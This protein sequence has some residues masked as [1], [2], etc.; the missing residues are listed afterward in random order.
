MHEY[1]LG[2]ISSPQLFQHVRATVEKYRAVIDLAAFNKNIIDPIKL[3]FDSKIYRKS[4][5]ESVEIEIVRQLDKS[6]NNH[7]GYF[8]Q[9][10]FQYFEGWQVPPSGYDI[11]HRER[12]IYVEMKNKHNTMNSSSSQKTYMRMQSTLLQQPDAECLLVEVIAKKSQNVP[13]VASLDGDSV[14][15][16]RIRRVSIDQFYQIVTGDPFAFRQLC[17]VLPKVIDDVIA[18]MQTDHLV[19]NSVVTQLQAQEH[20]DLLRAIY[21]T[22]F[23]RYQG[24]DQLVWQA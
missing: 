3:T 22:S 8:H 19:Q 16:P 5:E 12:K 10:I 9:N 18:S 6:N 21:L 11:I 1:A 14:T 15:H 13:W 20:D 4:I 24:F 17:A 2:F 23:G 7:I